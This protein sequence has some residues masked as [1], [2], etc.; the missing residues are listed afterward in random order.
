MIIP[1][2]VPSTGAP[3]RTKSRSAAGHHQPVEPVQIGGHADLA[4]VGAE[5][6]Q[7]LRV[8]LEVSL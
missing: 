1:A 2:Q 3:E 4:H 5:A 6:A 7:H 8:G